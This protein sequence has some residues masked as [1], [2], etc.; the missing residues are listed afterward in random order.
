MKLLGGGDGDERVARRV[1]SGEFDVLARFDDGSTR[2]SSPLSTAGAAGQSSD[3][4][5]DWAGR[6]D[7]TKQS[8]KR[9]KTATKGDE[10]NK[11]EQQ[12][13]SREQKK[14]EKEKLKEEA[15]FVAALIAPA[16]TPPKSGVRDNA[17][18]ASLLAT[19][20]RSARMQAAA[21]I[22]YAA[23]A[24]GNGDGIDEDHDGACGDHDDDNG[25]A[26]VNVDGNGESRCNVINN[27]TKSPPVRATSRSLSA[28][29][30]DRGFDASASASTRVDAAPVR[31]RG[32]PTA[33]VSTRVRGQ[34]ESSPN[35]AIA[36]AQPP[37][38]A[39]QNS[40]LR[41]S[42]R[43]SKSDSRGSTDD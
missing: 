1:R 13:Q 15:K 9:R 41:R 8:K 42:R 34:G 31:R 30:K 40:C 29:D 20:R 43:A 37:A 10:K 27:K 14:K 5:G 38:R 26:E 33:R 28:G 22:D 4:D 39:H 17:A 35:A 16:A 11:E 12:R 21:R 18:A 25:G 24:S 19:T 23:L 6:A 32:T 3:S 2:V 7:E 36:A